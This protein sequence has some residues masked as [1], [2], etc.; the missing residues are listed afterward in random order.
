MDQPTS[1]TLL[2]RL[3][4][5]DDEAAWDAFYELYSPMIVGFAR[6]CGC[7]T[8]L[9]YDVLQESMVC[10][11]RHMDSFSYDPEKGRFRSFLLRIVHSRVRDAFRRNRKY[12]GLEQ[13]SDTTTDAAQKVP[14]PEEEPAAE[15]WDRLWK[16]NLLVRALERVKSKVDTRTFQSFDLYVLR[17]RPAEQVA[18]ELGFTPNVVYQQRVRIIKMLQKEVLQLQAETGG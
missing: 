15:L 3:K 5:Q 13:N 16:C 12:C 7:S 4:S 10:L 11:L 2:M 9:A 17:N 8:A 18:A 6:Q 1:P 14:A